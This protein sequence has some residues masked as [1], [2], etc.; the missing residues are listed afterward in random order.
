MDYKN[1]RSKVLPFF[2]YVF[3]FLLKTP[4]WAILQ[5][6]VVLKL[7]DVSQYAAWLLIHGNTVN[8]FICVILWLIWYKLHNSPTLA[9]KEEI[10]AIG[11]YGIEKLLGLMHIMN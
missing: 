11:E 10:E 5:K 6:E 1:G 8:Q 7:N 9:V 2:L 4:D 3:L